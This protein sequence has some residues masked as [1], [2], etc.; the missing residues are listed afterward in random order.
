MESNV[1]KWKKGLPQASDPK[2]D[3][4]IIGKAQGPLDFQCA[5]RWSAHLRRSSLGDG[6]SP[7]R[8]GCRRHVLS[9]AS[10]AIREPQAGVQ[11]TIIRKSR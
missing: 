10:H 2:Y 6:I 3:V 5:P 11:S 4:D 9:E 7:P 8:P 1:V